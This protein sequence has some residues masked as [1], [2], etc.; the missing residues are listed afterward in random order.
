ME[1]LKIILY[2]YNSF[3]VA[4]IILG[5][6]IFRY[7]TL[8]HIICAYVLYCIYWQLFSKAKLIYTKNQRN[9]ELLK[10]C[11]NLLN[12]IYRPN[13]FLPFCIS[14][15]LICE[16]WHPKKAKQ[17]VYNIENVNNSG[18]KLYW[19]K[20]SD[21]K[22][23]FTNEPI[24]LI[25]PGM[26]GDTTDGYVQN[27]L[28]EGLYKGYNVVMY[29]VRFLNKDFALGE[30]GTFNLYE[31]IDAAIDCITKKY[32]NS[33]I[34]AISG[35]YGANNLVYYLGHINNTK[36]RIQAAISISNPYDM[37]LSERFLED[38]FF[39][40]IITFLERRNFK[41][42]RKVVESYKNIDVNIDLVANC[43]HLKDYDEEFSRK[44]FGFK[45]ADD[46]YRNISSLRMFDKINIPL[47]CINSKD[48]GFVS[49]RSI[50]Y[51]D[52]RLNENILLLVTDKGAHMCFFSN[53]KL[54]ELKQWHLKPMFEFFDSC[55]KML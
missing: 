32:K 25:F 34:F 42:I 19:T 47:L 20:F 48:D 5:L 52:I 31:D 16:Y 41:K 53:E 37:E 22:E 29:L 15:M 2:L 39:G 6:Y 44:I 55:Q 38:T 43:R 13:F 46:Y 50:P 23:E 1:I 35:S 51:D 17:L 10:N 14:Q 36:K 27:I 7:I 33:K 12:P 11:P 26:T 24:L 40:Y 3:P 4:F 54:F 49:F 45:S 30:K 28:I 9:E 8:I 21:M 18:T